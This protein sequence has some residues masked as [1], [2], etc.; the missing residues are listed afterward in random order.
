[1]KSTNLT[2]AG[3]AFLYH[4]CVHPHLKEALSSVALSCMPEHI[5]TP[6]Q[7]LSRERPIALAAWCSTLEMSHINV[8]EIRDWLRENVHHER[9]S[10]TGGDGSYQH[11]L[12]RPSF[13]AS[14]DTDICSERKL[15]VLNPFPNK[16]ARLKRHL[17][18]KRRAI[19]PV[20][21]VSHNAVLS[22]VYTSTFSAT[23]S[24]PPTEPVFSKQTIVSHVAVTGESSPPNPLTP[25]PPVNLSEDT[26]FGGSKFGIH[27]RELEGNGKT[28]VT[29]LPIQS[30]MPTSGDIAQGLTGTNLT[31]S[32]GKN[33]SEVMDH[34]KEKSLKSA[35]AQQLASPESQQN[36]ESL[37]LVTNIAATQ[38]T[39][40]KLTDK[41]RLS[42][43]TEKPPAHSS[44]QKPECS[45]RQ[46]ST[47][48]SPANV[49]RRLGAGQQK[50]ADI[51]VSTPRTEEATWAAASLIFL[52]VL[53]T[54]SVLYTQ[55]YKK[56][57]KSQSLYWASGSTSEET[58]TVASI[59]KRRL[60]QGHS[61][62]KK[63]IGRKK[64][65]VRLYESLSE[66]SD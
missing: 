27:S 8:T 24:G 50:N 52:L 17:F 53:L 2:H 35:V 4:P 64:S 10:E 66:S 59:I 46:D 38:K 21:P 26:D 33:T 34:D 62:R 7:T 3:V 39:A 11:L 6:L 14:D 31:H 5:M 43:V 60:V 44:V 13:K 54:F 42:S 30:H 40:D 49:M 41:N 61:K 58:E 48:E 9:P 29:E 56:F 16:G 23:P 28:K 19:L 18:K 51:Y 65:P 22:G 1:M 57:R 37:S 12:I 36:K 45:C 55:I 32:I 20:T 63:W 15:R 25:T 47:P